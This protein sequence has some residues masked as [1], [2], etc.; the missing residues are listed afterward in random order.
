MD[1]LKMTKL[2]RR[3]KM[4]LVSAFVDDMLAVF[5]TPQGIHAS[6][7]GHT[8]AWGKRVEGTAVIAKPSLAWK[9]W[10]W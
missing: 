3:E 6:E 4:P 9:G 8:V 10:K 5:G 1:A 7:N 2:E